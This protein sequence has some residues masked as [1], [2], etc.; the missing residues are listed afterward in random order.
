MSSILISVLEGNHWGLLGDTERVE[1]FGWFGLYC[2]VVHHGVTGAVVGPGHQAV[3]VAR[4]SLE[5]RLH[6]AVGQV[7]DPSRHA[8]FLGQAPAG[9]AEEDTLDPAGDQDAV[10][11]HKQTVRRESGGRD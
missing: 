3:N 10:A 6:S 9:I 1:S 8:V 2:D 5:D 7:A 4:R 11:D